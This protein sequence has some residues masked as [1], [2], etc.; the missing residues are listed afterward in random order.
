MVE[1][2]VVETPRQR[3]NASVALSSPA[4][5]AA[6]KGT[7]ETTTAATVMIILCVCV[8]QQAS[9]SMRQSTEGL[10]L[11]TVLEVQ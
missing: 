11:C 4:V 6:T 7:T 3:W 1:V 9:N 8:E 2:V 10:V 5:V